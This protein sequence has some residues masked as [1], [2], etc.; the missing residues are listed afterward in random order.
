MKLMILN[1][2]VQDLKKG[3]R[4]ILIKTFCLIMLT[5]QKYFSDI[6]LFNVLIMLTNILDSLSFAQIYL[7]LNQLNFRLFEGLKKRIEKGM[8]SLS[9]E[10]KSFLLLEIILQIS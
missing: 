5:S 4:R 8:H 1:G 9:L 3:M 2:K 10:I 6:F 7:P